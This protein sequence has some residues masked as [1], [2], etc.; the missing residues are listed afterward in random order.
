[1]QK[2]TVSLQRRN[3]QHLVFDKIT[4]CVIRYFYTSDFK[5]HF[6][7]IIINFREQKFIVCLVNLQAKCEIGLTCKRILA[8]EEL[9]S[10]QLSIAEIFV[11]CIDL[12]LFSWLI[13]KQ[14][15]S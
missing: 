8:D 15:K 7:F 13:Q 11:T 5:A 4:I 2:K 14:Q 6:R 12:A 10:H 9:I 1:M 3:R